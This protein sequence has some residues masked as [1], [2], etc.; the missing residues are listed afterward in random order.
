MK[1]HALWIDTLNMNIQAGKT[2]Q[3]ALLC[4][5]ALSAREFSSK[6]LRQWPF[7]T[8]NGEQTPDSVALQRSVETL[9][10]PKPLTGYAKVMSD[11]DT[12]D[13]PL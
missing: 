7:R 11:P 9:P 10:Q 8:V 12:E 5:D 1:D 3:E 4:A 13:A 6:A 2:L